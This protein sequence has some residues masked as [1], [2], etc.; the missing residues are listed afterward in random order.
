MSAVPGHFMRE[1]PESRS[2]TRDEPRDSTSGEQSESAF[3]HWFAI[4]VLVF[5]W[6]AEASMCAERGF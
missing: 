1:P 3:W 4:A 5:A 6:I 2:P